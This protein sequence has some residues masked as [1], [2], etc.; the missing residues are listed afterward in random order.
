MA[1][2]VKVRADIMWAFL[3]KQNEMSGK[4]Q[5]D[6]CNLSDAA[7]AALEKTGLEV[8]NKEGKGN[9][10]TCKSNHPIYAY[11]DG[12]TQIDGSIV[13]NGSKAAAL[14]ETYAWKFKGKQGVGAGIKKLVITDLKEYTPG[15]ETAST[16]PEDE[17][18]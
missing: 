16:I 18:L 14:V 9:F 12:G 3:T 15:I 6:L 5:V 11:D 13:G 4:Y 2:Q 17:L 8:R 1:D 10:V 7:V